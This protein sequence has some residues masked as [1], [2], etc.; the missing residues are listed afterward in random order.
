MKQHHNKMR[1]LIFFVCLFLAAQISA[2]EIEI[3]E[4]TIFDVLGNPIAGVKILDETNVEIAITSAEGLFKMEKEANLKAILKRDGYVSQT[5]FIRYGDANNF[6]MK[7][8]LLN[9]DIAVGYGFQKRYNITGSVASVSDG[10]LSKNS[11]SKPSYALYGKLSGLLVQEEAEVIGGATPNMWIRGRSTYGNASNV[12]IVLVDGFARNIDDINID[13]IESVNVL[14]DASAAVIYGMKGANGVILVETKRGAIGKPRYK[15]Q[16]EQGFQTPT[17]IVDFTNSAE[18]A[19]LYNQALANDGLAPRFSNEDIMGFEQGNSIYYPD[20]QW[21]DIM[22][23]NMAPTTK[24]AL[25]ATGGNKLAKYYVSLGYRSDN[26]FLNNTKFMDYDNNPHND[27]YSLRTNLDIT[28][29][30]NLDLKLDISGQI[31]DLTKPVRDQNSIWDL[32]YRYPQN[33]FPAI[34]HDGK[35]GGT[36]TFRENP[37]GNIGQ[38]G[39]KQILNRHIQSTLRA[40]YHLQGV[41]KG[42]SFGG[43]YAFDNSWNITQTRSRAYAVYEIMGVGLDGYPLLATVGKDDNALSYGEGSDQQSRREHAEAFVKYN[44]KFGKSHL[45]SATIL[46]HQD[47]LNIDHNNPYNN[48]Y[49][50]GRISY[51]YASKYLADFAFSYSGSEAFAKKYRYEFYPAGALAWVISKEDFMND[52]NAV[53]FL[54]LRASAGLVGNSNINERFSYRQMVTWLG[55][56]YHFGNTPTS[57]VGRT[58]GTI[59]NPNLKAE[60]AFKVD[61][62]IDAQLFNSLYFSGTYFFEERSDILSYQGNTLSSTFGAPYPNINVGVAQNYGVELQ[63][64]FDKQVSNATRLFADFNF[65]TYRN[66]VKSMSESPLPENSVYQYKTGRSIESELRL[67]S[68]GLFQSQEEIDRSPQQEFGSVRPGDIK[69][70]DMNFDGVINDYDRV[71]SGKSNMPTTDLGLNLGVEFRNWDISAFFHA[72]LGSEIYLGDASAIVQP[73]NN[74]AYRV[75]QWVSDRIPWTSETAGVA[76]FPRLSTTDNANNYRRS[77]Y[78]M[79][80]GDRLRL[81]TLEI[82]YNLPSNIAAK[83]FMSK[84]RIYLR[85]INLLTFDHLEF[86]DPAAMASN[87]M[88]RSYYIGCSLDF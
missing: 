12:P 72:Q 63:L 86:L 83:A 28:A 87:P 31:N 53:D 20:N 22:T 74:S 75:S 44:K 81:R 42:F 21:Q 18:A 60:K 49:G 71:Y 30:D 47:R 4:G 73:F 32:L 35:L 80:N 14:K 45:L 62:G 78:W 57:Y 24:I 56:N 43:N 69:Y 39:Y 59:A 54:K 29:L 68:D 3:T 16:V 65:L 2:Q 61:L 66:K 76:N 70:K 55:G 82:G 9:E 58:M 15:V 79:V 36:A 8:N 85:G 13:D 51:D 37:I 10:V 50:G 48:Q 26:S 64:N 6:K 67:V 52:I 38:G 11:V 1:T 19:I 84:C 33:E 25:S 88:L 40:E 7:A 27:R 5:V 17:R 77:D 46:Y 41:L 34:F 23:K